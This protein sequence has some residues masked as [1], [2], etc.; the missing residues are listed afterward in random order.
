MILSLLARGEVYS[1]VDND[2]GARYGGWVQK[3]ISTHQKIVTMYDHIVY[4]WGKQVL[5][6]GL[7]SQVDN[8]HG[9][10][11]GGLVP[12]FISTHQKIV[13]M[14]DRILLGGVGFGGG[15]RRS[16]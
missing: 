14:D 4:S 8:D 16:C 11:Y 12:K 5:G 6:V 10:R 2:H 1:Q 15:A 7:H 13:T 3:F 9:A